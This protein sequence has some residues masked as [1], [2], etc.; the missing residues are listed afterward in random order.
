MPLKH[1]MVCN[2]YVMNHVME[3]VIEHVMEHVVRLGSM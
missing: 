1:V 2:E 3:Y